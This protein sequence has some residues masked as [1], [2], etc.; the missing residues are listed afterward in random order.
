MQVQLIKQEK[1]HIHIKLHEDIPS[2][3]WVIAG[4]GMSGKT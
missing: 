3:F 1:L 2:S 4:T